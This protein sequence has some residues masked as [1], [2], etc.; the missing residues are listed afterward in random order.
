VN[1]ALDRAAVRITTVVGTMWCAMT[2]TGIAL[3]SLPGVLASRSAVVIV[4]WVSQAFLQL[5]LLS[6]IM[7]GQSAQGAKTEARDQETH[8]AVM[9]EHAEIKEIVQTIHETTSSTHEAIM[10][11]CPH[12]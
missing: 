5:V 4:S 3:V 9:A 10:Q 12:E 8:D 7:V 1:A 6:I 11:D 2:F